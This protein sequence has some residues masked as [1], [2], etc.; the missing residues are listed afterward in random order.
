[1]GRDRGARGAPHRP[2]VQ[3]P[4]RPRRRHGLT[5]KRHDFL[6]DYEVGF[7]DEGRIR[8]LDAVT[9]VALRLFGRPVAGAINDRAMFHADNAYY[10][11]AVDDHHASG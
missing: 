7:D 8:A 10:L 1:M 3:D 11:P 6:V 4:A 9:G 5:G 2:A